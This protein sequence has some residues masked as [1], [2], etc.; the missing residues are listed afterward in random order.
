MTVISLVPWV[1]ASGYICFFLGYS[2][3]RR[4]GKKEGFVEGSSYAPLAVREESYKKGYCI[5]C[6]Q[7]E[8]AEETNSA[9]N[10]L[11]DADVNN[12]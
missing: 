10:I 4:V 7:T 8:I 2:L 3:G 9:T 11:P 12:I 1:I 6:S 5:I